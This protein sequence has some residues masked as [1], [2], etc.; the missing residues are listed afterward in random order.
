MGLGLSGGGLV[1]AEASRCTGLMR[2]AVTRGLRLPAAALTRVLEPTATIPRPPELLAAAAWP[3]PPPL[4]DPPATATEDTRIR[5]APTVFLIR[6]PGCTLV[7]LEG[8]YTCAPQY[9]ITRRPRRLTPP[10]VEEA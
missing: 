4:C 1:A 8:T 7:T 10:E 5:N 6:H 9:S 2:L 3:P